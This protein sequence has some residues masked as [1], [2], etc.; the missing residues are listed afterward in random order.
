[1]NHKFIKKGIAVAAIVSA[2]FISANE[3]FASNINNPVVFP[4]HAVQTEVVKNGYLH[5]AAVI[6][7]HVEE[8]RLVQEK[9]AQEA[10]DAVYEGMV[11]AKVSKGSYL[12]IRKKA[13][14]QSAW[15]GRLYKN[16]MAKVIHVG[17]K[18]L[19]IQSGDVTGYVRAKDVLTGEKAIEKA[20]ELVALEYPET[21]IDTLEPEEIEASFVFAKSKKMIEAES[22][23]K[24]EEVVSYA[25][26]F[27]GNP[28]VWGGLSLTRGTDCSG[29]VKLVYAKFGVNLPHSSSA[30]RRVGK[31]V[32]Y[33]NVRKGDIICY[34]GHVGIYAGNGQIVNASNKAKGIKFSSATYEPIITVR[35]IF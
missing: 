15:V 14:T 17:K 22:K 5:T 28:Y 23:K 6:E 18:W 35:R 12:N 13:S 31:E 11:F 32:S 9:Q 34:N 25:N 4:Y 21:D 30:M 7:V 2:V 19:K 26:Q 10:R 27:L 3:A 29:F 16:S 33:S 1:M 20:R 8:E 24:G